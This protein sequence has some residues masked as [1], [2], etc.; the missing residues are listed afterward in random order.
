MGFVRHTG[1]RFV[2]DGMRRDSL[3][4]TARRGQL[5]KK[6]AGTSC[7]PQPTSGAGCEISRGKPGCSFPSLTFPTRF[8]FSL[9]HL[10]QL[11]ESAGFNFS[12]RR[13][14]VDEIR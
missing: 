1:S 9:K 4:A 5:L 13:Q 2:T 8:L 14:F 3:V 10:Q 6:S 12:G 11:I 7:V